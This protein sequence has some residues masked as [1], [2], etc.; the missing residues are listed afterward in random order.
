[1]LNIIDR[2]ILH[3]VVVG[4]FQEAS[5]GWAFFVDR[6]M[7]KSEMANVCD[8][9]IIQHRNVN[10]WR[11][12]DMDLPTADCYSTHQVIPLNGVIRMRWSFYEK[13]NHPHYIWRYL[14]LA[15]RNK[16]AF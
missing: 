13:L 5:P 12:V 9:N 10:G 2:C 16:T 8:F 1:M 4:T 11:Q 6:V 14:E 7:L 15:F 3:K